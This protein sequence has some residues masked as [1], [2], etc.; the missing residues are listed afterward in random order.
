LRSC[1]KN[2]IPASLSFSIKY[3]RGPANGEFKGK[4]R[5][6]KIAV[7]C[8]LFLH[9]ETHETT[10]T[11]VNSIVEIFTEITDKKTMTRLFGEIFTPAEVQDVALR[12]R[13]MKMLHEGIPQ[14]E[15]AR[16]LGISLCKITRGSRILKSQ[17]S[18]SKKILDRKKGVRHASRKK[19]GTFT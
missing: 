9:I 5:L 15:I 1:G 10:M 6:D 17:K 19:T 18:V 16:R 14:R 2:G 11:R 3:D 7:Y 12:W 8:I 13:L 4:K